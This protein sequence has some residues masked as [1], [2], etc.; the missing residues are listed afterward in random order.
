MH[1]TSHAA[2]PP[3]VLARVESALRLAPMTTHELARC[4]TVGRASVENAL[5]DLRRCGV[6]V[7][8]DRRRSQIGSHHK[9]WGIR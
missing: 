5:S 6:I 9:V 4:L 7:C 3:K 2:R 1:Q 8:V